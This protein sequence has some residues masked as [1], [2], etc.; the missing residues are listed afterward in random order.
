VIG[1]T[2]LPVGKNQHARPLLA[3]NARDFE[4]ILPVVFDT[5]VGNIKRVA[6]ANFQ[7]ARR[8]RGFAGAFFGGTARSHFSLGQVKDPS[9][10]SAL[11]HL[12]QSS[13]AGLFHIVAVSGKGEKVERHFVIL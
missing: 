12:K 5:A 1:V 4:P 6:P 11:G 9:A 8:L 10:I 2:A 3:E 13:A 7:D